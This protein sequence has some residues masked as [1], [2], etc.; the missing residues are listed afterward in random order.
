MFFPQVSQ[1]IQKLRSEKVELEQDETVLKVLIDKIK[2]QINAVQVGTTKTFTLYQFYASKNAA[3][4][5]CKT[6]EVKKYIYF[7]RYIITFLSVID[8]IFFRFCSLFVLFVFVC[9]FVCFLLS[10]SLFPDWAA[11]DQEPWAGAER[12]VPEGAGRHH[13]PPSQPGHPRPDGQRKLCHSRGTYPTILII[14]KHT[15]PDW[16][17]WLRCLTENL[18]LCRRT[19]RTFAI[20]VFWRTWTM[21]RRPWPTVWWRPTAS[22]RPG[23]LASC[24]TWTAARTSRSAALQW[25]RAPSPSTTPTRRRS[26][27][28]IS[29]IHQVW[30]SL[31]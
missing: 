5:D 15:H 14:K 12:R 13:K 7:K 1:E 25:S 16:S 27:W 19:S 26:S 23:W 17:R 8:I 4:Q 11:W 9:V 31:V 29:W 2:N 18:N 22:F 20:F 21:G 30:F 6:H 24:A 28:S 3:L 10:G